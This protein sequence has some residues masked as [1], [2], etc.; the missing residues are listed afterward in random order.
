MSTAL[1]ILTR[2]CTCPCLRPKTLVMR[3]SRDTMERLLLQA[4]L[5]SA[6][7]ISDIKDALPQ[8]SKEV[9]IQVRFYRTTHLLCV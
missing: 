3:L 7:P 5:S 6:I 8:F 2:M 9:Q 1:P 4:V